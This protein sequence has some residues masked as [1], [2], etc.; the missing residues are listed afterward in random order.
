[1]RTASFKEKKNIYIYF[2]VYRTHNDV[3]TLMFLNAYA[4]SVRSKTTRQHQNTL[5]TF[6]SGEIFGIRT[7]FHYYYLFTHHY[8]EMIYRI[9]SPKIPDLIV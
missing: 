5:P 2:F 7:T 1:V 9:S 8:P 6:V 4:N 3:T